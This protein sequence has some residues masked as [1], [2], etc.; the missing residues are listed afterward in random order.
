[1]MNL[2]NRYRTI[3]TL[4]IALALLATLAACATPSTG[5]S[6]NSGNNSGTPQATQPSATATAKPKPTGVPTF[7]VALCSQLMSV[8][9]ANSLIQPNPPIV[10]IVPTNGDDGGACNY[11]VSKSVIPLIIYFLNWNGPV[12]VPQSDIEAALSQAAGNHITVN[13]LTPVTGI[14]DQAEY[15]EATGSFEGGTAIAHVFYVLDGKIG[16]DCFN[17]SP[18]SGGTMASQSAL[19]TCATQV[20]NRL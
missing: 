2:L 12:P 4:L 1:M 19:Q 11:A 5:N 13:T 17:Y 10:A 3:A 20:V 14:G 7:T 9:E 8:D 18:L 6:G 16:F 15:V